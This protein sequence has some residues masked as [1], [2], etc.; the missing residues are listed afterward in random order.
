MKYEL[1]KPRLELKELTPKENAET[2]GVYAGLIF[3]KQLGTSIDLYRRA[4]ISASHGKLQVY[5]GADETTKLDS[6]PLAS[7]P[8]LAVLRSA[9][10][11]QQN[12]VGLW[13]IFVFQALCRR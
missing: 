8:Y 6:Q 12:V 3:F 5:W 11:L 7:W 9:P 13:S 10:V 4:S 1:G 2:V